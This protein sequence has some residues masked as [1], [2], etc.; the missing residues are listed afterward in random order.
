MMTLDYMGYNED[1]FRL[2]VDIDEHETNAV[3]KEMAPW[4]RE[5]DVTINYGST[6]SGV[7][8]YTMFYMVDVSEVSQIEHSFA[9]LQA[10]PTFK[11]EEHMLGWWK[12]HKKLLEL[13]KANFYEDE[14]HAF[15]T[16]YKGNSGRIAATIWEWQEKLYDAYIEEDIYTI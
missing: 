15:G 7:F 4:L 6:K 11:K 16:I 3:R 2:V 1:D 8:G 12:R 9:N 10:S 5:N 13:F 14:N